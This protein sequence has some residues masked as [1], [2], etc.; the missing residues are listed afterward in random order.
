ME[1]VSWTT[2]ELIGQEV[3]LSK[4][5]FKSGLPLT[6]DPVV[7]ER[8]LVFMMSGWGFATVSDPGMAETEHYLFPL[9]VCP[10]RK[11]WITSAVINKKAMDVLKE[12]LDA[13]AKPSSPT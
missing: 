12:A 6:R 4:E 11:C 2:R 3:Y 7:G 5:D 9:E 1:K 13:K 10:I 8:L